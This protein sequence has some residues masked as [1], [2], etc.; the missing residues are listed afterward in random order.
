MRRSQFRGSRESGFTLIE[1]AIVVVII[2]LLLGGVLKGQELIKS[3][4]S[5]N[6]VSQSNA[7]KAAI[8]G[9]SDRY[10]A[11]PGDYSRASG[12][13]PSISANV[14]DETTGEITTINQEGNGDSL[15]GGLPNAV[16][17]TEAVAESGVVGEA[18][19]VAPVEATEGGRTDVGK[20]EVALV[21]LHLGNAGYISGGFTG[22]E[23]SIDESLWRC[24]EDVCMRNA[25][26]SPLFIIADNE[27]TGSG[28]TSD[29][30]ITNQLWSGE[31]I[32]VEVIADIDNKTDDGHPGNGNFRVSDY[33]IETCVSNAATPA[34]AATTALH[35]ATSWDV[36]DGV[37][38]GGVFMF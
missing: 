6:L 7:L 15:I 8:L 28:S 32:P 25:Y 13:I 33:H 36:L 21:W 18:G 29:D 27:Q 23:D 30:A 34:V 16:G 3:A 10:R 17:G 35:D 26:N 12:T 9:F 1:I 38:C 24:P 37:T 14:L 5:H 19:Y 11:L 22:E 2:G 4:R 31:K 20:A